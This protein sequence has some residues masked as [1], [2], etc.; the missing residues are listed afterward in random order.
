MF[1]L[2]SIFTLTEIIYKWLGSRES[3]LVLS[4]IS[5]WILVSQ[6]QFCLSK[7]I[8]GQSLLWYALGDVIYFRFFFFSILLNHCFTSLLLL[9]I[10]TF[11]VG[12]SIDNF[13]HSLRQQNI[14]L[15]VDAFGTRSGPNEPSYNGAITV[16]GDDKVCWAL[17]VAFHQRWGMAAI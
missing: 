7:E 4:L 3:N 14:A 16:S 8:L 6:H 17:I 5:E 13:I 1:I 9:L 15:E 10:F 12:S 11:M 2:N